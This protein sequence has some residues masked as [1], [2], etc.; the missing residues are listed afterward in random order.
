MVTAAQ[1]PR[2]HVVI[3]NV[4]EEPPYFVLFLLPATALGRL[5]AHFLQLDGD[6]D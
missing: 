3:K 4:Q 2:S 6:E 1:S 5:G